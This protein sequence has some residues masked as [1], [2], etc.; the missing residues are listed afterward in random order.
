MCHPKLRKNRVRSHEIIAS[1]VFQTFYWPSDHY[2]DS[3]EG[4]KKRA[5]KDG[6]HA[7]RNMYPQCFESYIVGKKY[8]IVNGEESSTHWLYLIPHSEPEMRNKWDIWRPL[9]RPHS[10]A[11]V[12]KFKGL[13]FYV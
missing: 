11:N 3:P 4:H 5:Q 2:N 9:L 8:I 13:G 6:R 1:S 12:L 10:S 7:K